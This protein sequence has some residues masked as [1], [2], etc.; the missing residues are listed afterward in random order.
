MD[1]STFFVCINSLR[2][3][4]KVAPDT[5]SRVTIMALIICPD[6]GKEVE[7]SL[8]NCPNCGRPLQIQQKYNSFSTGSLLPNER[9]LCSANWHAIVYLIMLFCCLVSLVFFV[10]WIMG[11]GEKGIVWGVYF[12]LFIILALFGVYGFIAINHNEFVITNKRIIIKSGII[13]RASYELRLEML[14]SIQ[15]YQGIFGRMLNYGTI[16]V[17]GVGA[18]RQSVMWIE[19]PLEFRQHIFKELNNN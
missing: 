3:E 17:H 4:K 10:L 12:P 18:S 7:T 19:S 15:I 5:K 6:C 1:G 2:A 13:R 16:L 9:I 11:V 14:E 8:K